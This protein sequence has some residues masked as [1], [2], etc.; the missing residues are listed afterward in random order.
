MMIL[1][2]SA[3]TQK[4]GSDIYPYLD[5]VAEKIKSY[6]EYKNWK[7][8]GLATITTMD[9]NWT[10]EA[11]LVVAKNV[12]VVNGER[13]EEILSAQETKKGKPRDITQKYAKEAKENRE[14]AR[15]R[16]AR[17]QQERGDNERVGGRIGLEDILP[18]SEKKRSDFSFQLVENV[19]VNGRPAKALEV[20]AKVKDEKNWEGRFFFDPLTDDLIQ[21]EVKPAANPKMVKEFEMKMTFEVI[22]GRYLALKSSR[23]KINGGIFLK[24]IR[25]VIEEEYSG[26]EILDDKN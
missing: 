14:K 16:R 1:G 10:A 17:E 3:F 21:V 25:Q 6:A 23:V 20:A 12:H 7:A 4:A 19:E 11:V 8:S 13:D 22:D 24:H 2:Q 15:K 9:K 18:F 26:F 5:R